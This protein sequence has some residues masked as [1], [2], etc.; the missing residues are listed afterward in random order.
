MSNYTLTS[1]VDVKHSSSNAQINMF[2]SGGGSFAAQL[3]APASLA[4]NVPF[5][6][7]SA[8]GTTGQFLQLGASSN[9]QWATAVNSSSTMPLSVRFSG[10]NANGNPVAT[11]STTYTVL[12]EAPN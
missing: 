8:S 11:G 7:P 2:P 4:G 12:D 6:L 3:Q 9:T 5:I 10:S 1:P